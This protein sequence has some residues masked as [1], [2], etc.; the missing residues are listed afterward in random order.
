MYRQE[1]II[2]LW[3]ILGVLINFFSQTTAL[4]NKVY[5]NMLPTKLAEDTL[6]LSVYLKFKK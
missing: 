6:R 1:D 2:V 4:S 5:H 3:K